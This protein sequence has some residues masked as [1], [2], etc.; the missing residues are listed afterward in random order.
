MNLN[1]VIFIMGVSGCGKST[2][3]QLLSER[4]KIPFFDG[5]DFH[6]QSGIGQSKNK[7]RGIGW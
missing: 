2:I 7:T 6:P 4:L 3:G 1:N 5:D